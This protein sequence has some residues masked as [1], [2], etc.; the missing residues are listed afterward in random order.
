M[1][2]VAGQLLHNVGAFGQAGDGKAAVG[3]SLI[4]ADDGAA[5]TAGAG[6]ILDL[7]HRAFH[8]F[9]GYTVKLPNYQSGQRDVL[10]GQHLSGAGLDIDLLGSLLD[11]VAGYA[12]Q[13]RN[14][15]P[16]VF[17]TGQLKLAVFI[18][19]EVAQIVDLAAA[20]IV[21]SI[22]DLELCTLQRIAGYRA[23]FI[24]GQAGF[25]M[26]FK[27]DGMISIGIQGYKLTGSIQQ[28]GR[29]NGLLGDFIHTGQQIGQLRAAVLVRSDFIHTMTVCGAHDEHSIGNGFSGV[30]I[31]LID[32]QVRP[33]L[34]LH[35]KGTGLAG[36][37]FHMV[38]TQVDDVICGG[39][40]FLHGVHTRLQI[41]DA[42]LALCIG[43]TVQIVTAVLDFCNTEGDASQTGAVRT[44]LDDFNGGLNGIGEHKLCIFIGVQLNDAL[45][46]I[47][48]IAGA[49]LLRY[50]IST[51]RQLTQVDFAVFVCGELF[52]AVI[53]GDGLDFKD[54]VGNDLAGVIAVHLHQAQA[55]FH[56]VEEQQFTDAVSGSQL[57]LLRCG[58]Q[59]VSIVAGVHLIG[60]I[61][62]GFQ[63]GQQNLAKLVGSEFA[64]RYG[65]FEYLKGHIGH[66][67]HVLAVVLDDAQT[68]QF[69]V[70][71]GEHGG[72]TGCNAC[73]MD[74]IILQPANRCSL[75]HDLVC[76]GF[77]FLKDG[78]AIEVGFSRVGDAAF[79]VLDGDNGT[80]QLHACVGVFLDA[81]IAV[82]L[83]F[84]G[85]LCHFAIFYGD[86]LRSIFTQQEKLGRFT[87]NDRVIAGNGQRDVD[88]AVVVGDKGSQSIA[89]GG[90]DLKHRS[91]QRNGSAS[92][93][94]H[95][96]QAGFHFLHR[97]IAIV[98]VSG[99]SDWSG[100]VRVANVIL[101]SSV[102]VCFYTDS[103]VN[104]IF[105]DIGRE[106]QLHTATLACNGIGRIQN[107]ELCSIALSGTCGGNCGNIL[108]IHVHNACALGNFIGI[109][110]GYGD[111]IIAHP[112]FTVDGEH[113]LFIL[114][115]I[116]GYGIG[117]IAVRGCGQLGSL[118]GA[119]CGAA[120]ID[121]LC[122]SKDFLCPFHL[123]AGQG[124]IDLQIGNVPVGKQV[125]PKSHFRGIVGV[126]LIL[127]LQLT[128]AAVRI[129]VCNDTH[130]L[131]I[132]GNILSQIFNALAFG[133]AL[134]NT[135]GV[136]VDAVGGDF[137]CLPLAVHIVI[138]SVDLLTD[139]SV[140]GQIGQPVAA[141]VNVHLAQCLFFGCCGKGGCGEHSQHRNQNEKQGNNPF[142]HQITSLKYGF[143]EKKS[144]MLLHTAFARL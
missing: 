73:G 97:L 57:H 46:L 26:V 56:I 81:E 30:C 5:R 78:A 144:G 43:G 117:F 25:L 16:T 19:V 125:A 70:N 89:V 94:L 141:I 139:A 140:D 29:R 130:D 45:C 1:A 4:S 110:K 55:G 134:G 27:V 92:L 109:S 124:G 8:G 86:I 60:Q 62:A 123:Y 52:G 115:A 93:I 33:D 63:I 65:V 66:G 135:L 88:L 12:L 87:L 68:G 13:F 82:R 127:Q 107:L 48:D 15:V 95:D 36:E 64:Q 28:I 31:V 75:L 112:G 51:G 49:G 20:G 99:Q 72:I 120:L 122:R 37:Q 77:D 11:G 6:Q 71:E 18:G 22:D 96:P 58:V 35:H 7:E 113:L 102:L 42:D 38:F 128:Q 137:L 67:Y 100:R 80:G 9:T 98:A 10:K 69:L 142:L 54:S 76:A 119:P 121:V 101:Q 111:V 105:V 40:R 138:V 41:A 61:S 133:Y 116:D 21:G 103:I 84:K 136:G 44:K 74:G 34:I 132:A 32:V 118:H 83:V 47:N 14:F 79:N 129:A 50:H 90:N 91:A 126:I 85:N 24:D 114:T 2:A 106:G 108:V 17:Q 3:R 59:D 39:C 104:C 131:G 53:T 143:G 23:D